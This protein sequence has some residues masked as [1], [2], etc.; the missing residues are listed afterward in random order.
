MSYLTKQ[1]RK[2]VEKHL[3]EYK[4]IELN[5]EFLKNRLLDL[6]ELKIEPS[7]NG[8]SYDNIK[9][10]STNK[11]SDSLIEEHIRILDEIEKIN[12]KIKKQRAKKKV[13]KKAVNSLPPRQRKV[14][15]E[16]YFKGIMLKEIPWRL[17]LD[18]KTVVSYRDKALKRLKKAFL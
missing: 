14:I 1:E 2:I 12:K 5:I 13:I 9:V 6:E 3:Y 7:M 11:I 17:G 16:I 10:S 8:I 4:Q 15:E 18:I